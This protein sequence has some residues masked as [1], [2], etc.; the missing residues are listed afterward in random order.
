MIKKITVGAD[1]E[2]FLFDEANNSF[3][4]VVG[5]IGG[6]KKTPRPI[7]AP[8]YGLQEDNVLLE[9]TIPPATN[10]EEFL[11]IINRIKTE[12]PGFIHPY[13]PRFVASARF[14]DR[15]LNSEQ[16]QLF[17]CSADYN[18]W[19]LEE[20]PRPNGEST[21]L[22]TS[23]MHI[24]VGY[25]NPNP[26]DNYGLLRAMDLFLGIP[27]LFY[28]Q[29]T[30]RRQLYGKAGCHRIKE[31]GIEYRVLSGYFLS[32]DE[33]IDFCYE[34]TERAINF[35]NE[36]NVIPARHASMIQKAINT[37]N[38]DMAQKVM[39]AYNIQIKTL[40]TA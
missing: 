5:L 14:D 30:D 2:V 26:P 35:V 22:R 11:H 20:N 27:S 1:I 15:E 28:D 19:T 23:G 17:G 16:A 39:D 4:S 25:E 3:K 13:V 33:M 31:Y 36:G 9:F 34:G 6:T 10:K 7:I 21:N 29:D 8:G 38:L 37:N 24:H 32:S 12:I 18:A 40:C